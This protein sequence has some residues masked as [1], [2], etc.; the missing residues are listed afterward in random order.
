MPTPSYEFR[1]AR[2]I[3][4]Q[5]LKNEPRCRSDDKELCYRVYEE[6]A[7]KHGKKIFI[8]FDLFKEFPSFETISRIRRKL[9]H[10]DKLFLPSNQTIQRRTEKQEWV[11]KWSQR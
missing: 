7:K 4:F 3:V 8:P 6:I 9:Q 1:T 5:L 2:G 11:R 10:K